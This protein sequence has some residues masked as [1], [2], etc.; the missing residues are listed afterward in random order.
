MFVHFTPASQGTVAHSTRNKN[1]DIIHVWNVA[2]RRA[3]AC[4][5]KE[6]AGLGSLLKSMRNTD[7]PTSTPV[8]EV[9]K[10]GM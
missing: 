9:W 8:S 5:Q 6:H 4:H 3:E 1:K 7:T 2:I 10:K